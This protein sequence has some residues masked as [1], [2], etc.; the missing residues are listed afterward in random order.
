MGDKNI[1]LIKMI[2]NKFQTLSK[3]QKLI[4]E[5]IMK[6]YDKAAFMTASKLGETVGVSE[7][8][9]VRFANALGF[10]GYPELQKSLQQLIKSK[11]T[12]VQ[13]ISIADEYQSKGGFLKQVMQSDINNIRLTLD[14]LD[15]S[16][17]NQVVDKIGRAKR[18][19]V[20]GLRSSTALAGYLGFYLNLIL[21]N[22]NVVSFG[23]SD[24]LEQLIKV[25]EDDLLIVISY[26]RYS[27]KTIQ[28]LEFARSRNCE[29][30]GIT[31]S[32]I[33]PIADLSTHAL[34]AKSNMA[35]FVDSLVG[36]MSLINALIV[37]VAVQKRE[38][39]ENYFEILEN[40]WDTYD[41]YEKEIER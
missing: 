4:A 9:V 29:I 16:V 39:V 20:L 5:F 21:D 22:V 40:V 14:E 23:L 2:Q 15:H 8:T 28:A 33:S 26:P 3:G 13:R 10:M 31:D 36:P 27:R 32:I 25:T 30:I 1:D 41:V 18:V 12:T 38:T 24:V 7:S 35:S 6:S 37:G 19:Y 17:F 11:L 34:I